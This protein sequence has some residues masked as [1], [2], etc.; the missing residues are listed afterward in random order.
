MIRTIDDITIARST[1]ASTLARLEERGLLVR[2]HVGRGAH[3]GAR[4]R[5][6]CTESAF[7]D[8]QLAALY[9][10]LDIVSADVPR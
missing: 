10:S 6:T 2:D 8:A 3:I 9:A 1:I 7:I 4:W 5:A